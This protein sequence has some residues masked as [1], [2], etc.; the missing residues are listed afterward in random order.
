M[1]LRKQS[2]ISTQN[3]ELGSQ[4]YIQN[5]PKGEPKSAHTH[6]LL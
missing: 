6:W 4:L 2:F 5:Q 3:R 1:Y